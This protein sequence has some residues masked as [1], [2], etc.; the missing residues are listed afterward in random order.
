MIV[1]FFVDPA[2]PWAWITSQWL[3]EVAPHRDLSV[4]WRTFSLER[5]DGGHLSEAIPKMFREAALGGQQLSRRAVRVLEAVRAAEGEQAVGDLYVALGSRMF[6]P[7]A[8]PSAPPPHT[9][10]EALLS[11]GL[12]PLLEAE[13]DQPTWDGVVECSMSEACAAVGPDAM[14][15]TIVLEGSERRGL[16]GPVLS[17]APT[18]E[19]AVRLWDAFVELMQ[20]PSFHELRRCRQT[21][22]FP[23]AVG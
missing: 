1:H 21:P 6:V 9:L 2:C 18:G 3:R 11:A 23:Q 22:S 17:S 12:D 20:A 8:P 14:I 13:G 16:C 19:S 4:R 15:P 7:G 10:H 5:R